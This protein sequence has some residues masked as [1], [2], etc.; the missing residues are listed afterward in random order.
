MEANQT[1]Q[2]KACKKLLELD[3][4]YKHKEC[5]K[6][7][8]SECKK[9]WDKK[10]KKYYD[11]NKEKIQSYKANWHLENKLNPERI[12]KRR[13]YERNK[14]KTDLKFKL[15]KLLRYSI[16]R[17]LKK[18]I[19]TS[20]SLKIIGCSLEKAISHIESLFKDGMTW[21]NHGQWHIDHIKPLSLAKNKKEAEKLCHYTNL[22][23]LWAVEN[24]K[25]GATYAKK[26]KAS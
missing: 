5:A 4:F 12:E 20:S 17:A 21:E 22:Q 2:C 15:H 19:K 11:S 1:K 16:R 3:L 26:S 13:A 14:W 9:C 6:G 25:K 18:R 7:V 23:P 10:T 8:R 24:I